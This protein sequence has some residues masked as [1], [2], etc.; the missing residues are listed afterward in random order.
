MTIDNDNLDA[1]PIGSVVFYEDD[2]HVGIYVGKLITPDGKKY[3]NAVIHSEKSY[4]V[5]VTEMNER[6]FTKYCTFNYIVNDI[7]AGYNEYYS[8]YVIMI[9]DE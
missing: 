5:H 9:D 3:E 8:P 4:G 6:K 2:S 1:I 7:P